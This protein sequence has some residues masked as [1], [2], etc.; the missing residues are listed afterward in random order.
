MY[1]LVFKAHLG[2]RILFYILF[3]KAIKPYFHAQDVGF[4][5]LYLVTDATCVYFTDILFD[6]VT[7]KIGLY[8]LNITITE[9]RLC[10]AK[11]EYYISEVRIKVTLLKFK[12][13]F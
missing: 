4:R 1:V 13:N 5:G 6:F 12:A 9:T 11:A 8:K 3:C 10:I 7:M 2:F